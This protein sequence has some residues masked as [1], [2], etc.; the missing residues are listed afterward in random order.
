MG[1]FLFFYGLY[2][3]QG[4]TM[5][6]Q[7]LRKIGSDLLLGLPQ[8]QIA[9]S[10]NMSRS[11][12][13]RVKQKLIK[14][15]IHSINDWAN[16]SD[17][18]LKT[19]YYGNQSQLKKDGEHKDLSG[20]VVLSRKSQSNGL[21]V[22]YKSLAKQCID[23]N[24][25][26]HLLYFEYKDECRQ[27]GKKAISKSQF[28]KRLGA[29]IKEIKGPEVYMIQEHP[30]GRELQ[31]DFAGKKWKIMDQDGELHEYSICI[32]T[33]ARS[34]YT[35]AEFTYGQRTQDVCKV[36]GNGLNYFGCKPVIL[37]CDNAKSMVTSHQVGRE[38]KLNATF[39]YFMDRLGILVVP[40]NPKSPTS[41][42]A[43]ELSV[44]LLQENVLPYMT[45]GLLRS[46]HDYNVQLQDYVEKYINTVP[47]KEGGTGTPRRELFYK[48]EKRHAA[49]LPISIPNYIEHL[50]SIRVPKSYH[51]EINGAQYS[52]PH[53]LATKFVDIDIEEDQ[54]KVYHLH[55]LVACHSKAKK[56]ALI[57]DPEHMP[58][59][60]RAVREK[61]LKYK[62]ADDIL[63]AAEKISPDL[64]SLC[65][66]LMRDEGYEAK[67]SFAIY[68]INLFKRKWYERKMLN[69]SI[70]RMIRLGLPTSRWCTSLFDSVFKSVQLEAR[71]NKGKFTRQTNLDFV[72]DETTAYLR[73]DDA[74]NPHNEL[75]DK[76]Q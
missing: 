10:V 15:S 6:I 65:K 14:R 66:I 7:T 30:Y 55:S 62:N 53:R 33:W 37:N 25:K 43:C 8:T 59:N 20:S 23:G 63:I 67:R 48:Q 4:K 22:D 31:I 18:D 11:T 47:F 75:S 13:L 49:R 73:D 69:E 9:E 40:S 52:V 70:Q 16:L 54:I 5:N 50:S 68:A 64:F 41:K 72:A 17:E 19:L 27:K 61:K 1:S 3:I 35:Y 46:V 44:R 29:E 51:I 56:G 12:I 45:E 57:T 26:R 42:S 2:M 38:A 21:Q 24:I 58:E 76:E 60:H 74:F 34:N 32:L 28:Y 36:I 71:S 39:K